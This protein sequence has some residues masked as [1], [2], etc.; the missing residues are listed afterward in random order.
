MAGLWF[1]FRMSAT[2]RSLLLAG[3]LSGII[4]TGIYINETWI[5]GDGMIGPP[6]GATG[7]FLG[8]GLILAGIGLRLILRDEKRRK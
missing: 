6:R 2:A 8:I 4:G 1:T 5:S 7:I 3:V